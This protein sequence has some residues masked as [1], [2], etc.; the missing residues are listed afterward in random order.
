ML[1]LLC[2]TSTQVKGQDYKFYHPNNYHPIT[3][4]TPINESLKFKDIPIDGNISDM[5]TKLQ[6]I[7]Y[8]L[9]EKKNEVAVLKG[10]FANES[11][12][13]VL[14]ATPIT[15]QMHTITVSFE[16]SSWYSLK[17]QYEEIKRLIKDKYN[18]TPNNSLEKFYSPY[19][20]GDGYEMQALRND[21]CTYFNT[22]KIG[23]DKIGVYILEEKVLLLYENSSNK[24]LS[25]REESRKAYN[26]I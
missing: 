10:F 16:R 4:Q 7:G 25:K 17:S 5:V 9:D 8:T 13:I 20:E 1:C 22:F 14:Y 2:I 19:Y 3:P 26:D 11:C 23:N 18:T 21:K 15:L 6:E 12:E 24:A